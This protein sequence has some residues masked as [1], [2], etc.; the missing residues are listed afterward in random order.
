M[1]VR[2]NRVRKDHPQGRYDER[3]LHEPAAAY[4]HAQLDTQHVDA[5]ELFETA[6]RVV[7]ESAV[8]DAEFYETSEEFIRV[9][10]D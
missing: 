6:M 10:D 7:L 2:A 1:P 8:E 3:D 4:V 9:T 5:A